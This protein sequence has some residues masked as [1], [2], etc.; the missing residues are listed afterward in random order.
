MLR[1]LAV[2]YASVLICSK[3]DGITVAE[4]ASDEMAFGAVQA[5]CEFSLLVS[6]QN[7]FNLSLNA[8]D[9]SVQPV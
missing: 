3:D 8:L 4:T 2:N 7:H 5:L 9:D 6:S 1:T